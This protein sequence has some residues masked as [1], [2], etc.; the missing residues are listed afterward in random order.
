M[1]EADGAWLAGDGRERTTPALLSPSSS[2]T[3]DRRTEEEKEVP[4]ESLGWR[5]ARVGADSG[6]GIAAFPG[7]RATPSNKRGTITPP[8]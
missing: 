2:Q 6:D 8:P 3:R 5:W 1:E 4:R 7:R